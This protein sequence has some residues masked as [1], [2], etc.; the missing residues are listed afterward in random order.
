MFTQTRVCVVYCNPC[1]Y[2]GLIAMEGTDPAGQETLQEHFSDVCDSALDP[3][4]LA[5]HL[6]TK[7]IINN[8]AR[9][10]AK[11]QLTPKDQRLD[12]LLGQVMANGTPGAFQAFVEALEKHGA[13]EWIVKKLIG[14]SQTLIIL[15]IKSISKCCLY[16]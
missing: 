5:R 15:Y 8:N 6:F 12:N 2:T 10:A 7:K 3:S 9:E 1:T 14:N 4:V 16:V 13:H 11:Q